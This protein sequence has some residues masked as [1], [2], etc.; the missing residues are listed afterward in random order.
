MLAEIA[1]DDAS[2]SRQRL[3]VF[4]QGPVKSFTPGML[5]KEEY[6][7]LKQIV[8][9]HKKIPPKYEEQILIALSYFPEL[10]NTRIDFR[11]KH[12]NTSFSTRPTLI[13]VLQRSSSENILLL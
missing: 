10:V 6:A 7:A 9:K 11:F 13:S 1:G 12:T 3:L 2:W 5:T 8:G 4:C